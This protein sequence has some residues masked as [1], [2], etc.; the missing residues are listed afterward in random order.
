MT[1][2]YRFPMNDAAS[3][4]VDVIGGAE[5]PVESGVTLGAT[6]LLASGAKS[7]L[8]NGTTKWADTDA[9][10][11]T[12]SQDWSAVI[13]FKTIATPNTFLSQLQGAGSAT[14]DILRMTVGGH[15]FTDF[16]GVTG[17]YSD[18]TPTNDGAR[19]IAMVTFDVS[20]GQRRLY[21]DGVLLD[22]RNSITGQGAEGGFR[23]GSNEVNDSSQRV[24]G[25][26]AAAR[27]YNHVVGLAEFQ[28][29]MI[30]LFSSLVR[31]HKRSPRV[32]RVYSQTPLSTGT[33]GTGDFAISG[34]TVD[35]VDAQDTY[36]DVT[37]ADPVTVG[38]AITVSVGDGIYD[39]NGNPIDEAELTITASPS[40]VLIPK[41][42]LGIVR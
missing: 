16:G 11:A 2:I 36:V 21:R 30:E 13:V 33:V 18:P 28:A 34:N 15:L 20:A 38:D 6:S 24:E 3:P 26:M 10:I 37:F 41:L 25:Y 5:G 4:F 17:G 39:I 8:G 7:A 14:D 27:I 9:A 23:I 29:L 42:R 35:S 40:P 32:V 1:L 22:T 19:H 12:A 31:A